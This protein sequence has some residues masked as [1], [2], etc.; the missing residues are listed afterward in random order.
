ML[1]RPVLQR[2]FQNL[3]AA[4]GALDLLHHIKPRKATDDEIAAVH[5]REHI[6]KVSSA[7]VVFACLCH[8]LPHVV[9]AVG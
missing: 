3:L 1:T 6:A 4:C 8:T 2:R 9:V 5:T 7:C